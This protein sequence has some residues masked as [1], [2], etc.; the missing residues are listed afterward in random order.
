[1]VE[2]DGDEETAT[3]RPTQKSAIDYEVE[4]IVVA[5][6]ARVAD[7]LGV[8]HRVLHYLVRWT[9]YG[10]EHAEWLLR[11]KLEESA[12]DVLRAWIEQRPW[13]GQGQPQTPYEGLWP[14]AG[15]G[16]LPRHLRR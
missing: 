11:E 4:K 14:T 15:Y 16:R 7:H 8:Q 2:L 12:G 10:P 9:G 6:R 1:M 3:T 13:R 5:K